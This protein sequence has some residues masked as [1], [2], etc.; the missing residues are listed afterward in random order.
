MGWTRKIWDAKSCMCHSDISSTV[1]TIGLKSV[2][3]N[4]SVTL[5]PGG[6]ATSLDLLK[7]EIDFK[8][9]KNLKFSLLFSGWLRDHVIYKMF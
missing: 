4:P 5:F 9:K 3:I 2:K 7:K 1:R 6:Y 8:K